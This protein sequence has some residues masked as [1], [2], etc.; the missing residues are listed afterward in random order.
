MPGAGRSES[1][2][3]RAV[4]ATVALVAIVG[5]LFFGWSFSGS[6]TA[7]PTVIGLLVA[8]SAIGWT[9][10]SRVFSDKGQER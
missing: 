8:V 3:V 7:F 1:A 5:Y 6:E 10:Y 2:A 4:G 9:L